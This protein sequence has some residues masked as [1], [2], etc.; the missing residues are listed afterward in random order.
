M[1]NRDSKIELCEKIMR[2]GREYPKDMFLDCCLTVVFSELVYDHKNAP[3]HMDERLEHSIME[4]IKDKMDTYK[5]AIKMVREGGM[6]EFL[7]RNKG[8]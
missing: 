4:V 6:E 5:K 2:S 3:S 1:S 7:K 8:M